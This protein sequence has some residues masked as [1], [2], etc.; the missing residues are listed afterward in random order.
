MINANDNAISNP[1]TEPLNADTIGPDGRGGFL[2]SSSQ[3]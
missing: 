1:D 2:F 3:I